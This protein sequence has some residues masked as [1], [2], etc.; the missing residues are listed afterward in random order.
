MVTLVNSKKNDEYIETNYVPEDTMEDGY[1]K[2]RIS[3][4]SIAEQRLTPSD[5]TLKC[6][7]SHARNELRKI[8]K[9]G[10][11]PEKRVVMWY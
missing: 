7:F 3:D 1:I 10:S 4:G 8:I 11:E 9:E 2:M 6:Y 5:G